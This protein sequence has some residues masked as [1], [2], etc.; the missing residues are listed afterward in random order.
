MEP[1]TIVCDDTLPSAKI[2]MNGKSAKSIY[3][4]EV[5]VNVQTEGEDELGSIYINGEVY[6]IQNKQNEKI[7]FNQ[8]GLYEIEVHLK[9]QA[10]H[11]NILPLIRFRI[12]NPYPL[13][14]GVIFLLVM[15]IF[16][17]SKRKYK[18]K[19]E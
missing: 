16:L 8:A 13:A 1:I 11:T 19:D 3:W 10:G 12:I 2:T 15:M 4:K 5:E 18:K 7:S 17:Y 14:I 6:D 9:D